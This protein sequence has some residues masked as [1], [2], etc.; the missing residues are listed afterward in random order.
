MVSSRTWVW[1]RAACIDHQ[2]SPMTP[3]YLELSCPFSSA[4]QPAG[5]WEQLT[6][7]LYLRAVISVYSQISKPQ[8]RMRVRNILPGPMV[9]RAPF[10]LI[11]HF[12]DSQHLLD[13]P[14]FWRH[15]ARESHFL[16]EPALVS[17]L[18]Q[19]I[20]HMCRLED[21]STGPSYLGPERYPTKKDGRKSGYLSPLWRFTV[22]IIVAQAQR[23]F[24][25]EN[26][27]NSF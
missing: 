3:F 14:A 2:G 4:P 15:C 24:A 10:L 25:E 13:S 16:L 1:T 21:W 27:F 19:S 6:W 26:A 17:Y 18:I 11:S 9:L 23:R 12:L 22:L 5:T 20:S 7:Y 8:P